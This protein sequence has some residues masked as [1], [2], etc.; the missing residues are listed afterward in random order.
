MSNPGYNLGGP[1]RE[2]AIE[3]GGGKPQIVNCPECGAENIQGTD[4]CVNCGSALNT[5]D[6][7]P[8]TWAP[9]EGPPGEAVGE[10]ARDEPI[11]VSPSMSVREVIGAL[12]DA[13]R[14]CAVVVEDGRVVGIFTERDVLNKVTP[15]R[16]ELL[17]RP[18]ADVMTPDPIVLRE[19]E[20][21]LVA[22]NEMAI[23][24]FRHIPLVDDAGALRGILSG[25]DILEE[26]ERRVQRR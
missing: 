10:L 1:R 22:L 3:Q 9:G 21:I 25:R 15:R 20:S 18:V 23:G 26:I 14:G 11:Q 24:G 13:D 7:P 8:E 5:L 6:I 19:Q 4:Y 12:R 17:D 16:E 2:I